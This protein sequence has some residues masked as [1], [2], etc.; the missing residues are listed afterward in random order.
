[1]SRSS[2]SAIT[3][4]S[5]WRGSC[6]CTLTGVIRLFIIARRNNQKYPFCKGLDLSGLLPALTG[7][8]CP[9]VCNF[10]IVHVRN[11]KKE[12]IVRAEAD[13]NSQ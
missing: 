3:T 13:Y 12:F 9:L 2:N 10:W 11:S 7:T 5:A 4:G 8:A 6:F 1:M